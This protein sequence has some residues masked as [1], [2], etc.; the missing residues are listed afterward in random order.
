M[1]G[2]TLSKQFTQT[3]MLPVG[4]T[5][6]VGSA[7]TSAHP[8][9]GLDHL[10]R[11]GTLR[12]GGRDEPGIWRPPPPPP[13]S[14]P[15]DGDTDDD[16]RSRGFPTAGAPLGFANPA[17]HL[18]LEPPAKFDGR[19]ASS[20]SGWLIEMAHWVKLSRIPQDDLWDVIATRMTGGAATWINAKLRDAEVGGNQPWTDWNEFRKELLTQFE[21]LSKEEHACE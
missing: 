13:P 10:V 1:W 17:P 19:A 6:E 9:E 11:A 15:G 18:K 20:A 21:P 2:T 5:G 12:I 7:S 16:A 8:R 14:E 4:Q 3:M